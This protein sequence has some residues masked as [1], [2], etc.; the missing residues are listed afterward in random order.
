MTQGTIF[1]CAVAGDYLGCT[2]HGIVLTAR[3]DISHDKARVHNY[4]PIVSLDDWLHRDGRIILAQRVMAEAQGAMRSVLKAGGFSASVM[5][6]E[7]PKVVFDTLFPEGSDKK[8]REQ[9]EK[10]CLRFELAD[11][12]KASPPNEKLS[13]DLARAVPKVLDGLLVELVHNNLGG[14][15]FLNSI[16][17]GGP[18]LGY[19]I[20]VREVQSIPRELAHAV[21]VGLDGELYDSMCQTDLSLC[22]KL[23]VAR[24][25]FAYPLGQMLSPHLELLLQTFAFLF[26]RIGLTDPDK[27]YIDGL[28]SRQPTVAG[29]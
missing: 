7:A 12:C 3:C 26:S 10:A 17:P 21:A 5:E 14:F 15:Y 28:W 2:T 22:G 9:F 20:L 1:T 16:E 11:R 6:T 27:V 8:R 19:V 25:D 29:N 18:D 13:I 4:L 23:V 24:D